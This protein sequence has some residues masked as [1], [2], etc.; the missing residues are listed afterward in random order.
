[1]QKLHLVNAAVV[2]VGVASDGNV[3]ID[4]D[5]AS[6]RDMASDGDVLTAK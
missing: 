4:G 5:V 3:A 1:M 6:D 2:E